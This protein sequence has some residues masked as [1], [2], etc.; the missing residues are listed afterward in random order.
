MRNPHPGSRKDDPDA[1]TR[2]AM[3][4]KNDWLGGLGNLA[5]GIGSLSTFSSKK[6]KTKQAPI[7]GEVIS[8]EIEK[9]PID[10]WKYKQGVADEGSHIGPYAEDMAKLGAGDGQTIDVISA[11]GVNLA[12][13][14]GVAKRLSR[15]EKKENA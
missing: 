13:T 9:M 3:S 14:Q 5:Y 15:L 7:D 8:R 11:L 2:Y 12:A 1:Q 6:L 10:R 4:N